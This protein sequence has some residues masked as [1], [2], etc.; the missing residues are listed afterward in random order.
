MKKVTIPKGYK[1]IKNKV[2]LAL[3]TN[4][5]VIT[6]LN[7]AGKT[8]ILKYLCENYSNRDKVFFKTQ[9]TAKQHRLTL[10]Q[11]NR[12]LQ[13]NTDN[14]SFDDVM[15]NIHDAF[16]RFFRNQ[17]YIHEYELYQMLFNESSYLYNK[18]YEFL[19]N[20]VEILSSFESNEAIKKNLGLVTEK[21]KEAFLKRKINQLISSGDNPFSNSK[22]ATV[23]KKYLENELDINEKK[24]I[25]QLEIETESELRE[26]CR[27]NANIKDKQSFETYIY[28]LVS[29]SAIRVDSVI[30][31]LSQRIYEDARANSNR[32][33]T[34]KL[35]EKINNELEHY[36][37][38]KYRIV[39]PNLYSSRYE[40][41]FEIGG[42]SKT[43][44]HFDSLSSGEKVIFELM[45]YYF[46]ADNTH[47]LEMIILDEF[48]ANL[49]PAL[50]EIYLKTVRK[51]FCNKGII[52]ILTTHSPSTV[53]EVAP[54]ELYELSI[55]NNKHTFI[56]A[57]TDE[58]KK[59]ILHKL[60]PKFVYYSEFGNLEYVLSSKSD[61]IVLV[62]GKFDKQ[63]FENH[64]DYQKY[65]FIHCHGKGNIKN[66]L[67]CL[68][69]I[70]FLENIVK[71]KLII[72]L[73]DFDDAGR[74]GI[75]EI[76]SPNINHLLA[77]KIINKESPFIKHLDNVFLAMFEPKESDSWDLVD[78]KF[79]RHQ[80]LK[81]EGIEG[82]NR[83]FEML[84]KIQ[85]E[86]RK[87]KNIKAE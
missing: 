8:T 54:N 45:S 61:V 62:E 64:E 35:W 69:A 47:G 17:D 81:K 60:A 72:G 4:L 79:L 75:H 85:Q 57:E 13:R 33:K 83:Q 24:L 38:F 65:T 50:A 71:D 68:K 76:A 12:L 15:D 48:D 10:F 74:K 52:A 32:T 9:S 23:Y 84:R 70:P 26:E 44:I 5:A 59:S 82:L 46:M 20:I 77:G 29:K 86:F 53:A 36:P 63:N 28:E 51:Q 78:K 25:D 6:G 66:F 37:N 21:D 49:N 27:R 16:L 30:T 19:S 7:G 1:G 42:D 22:G 40:I 3:K 2:D 58:V 56:C 55:T 31:K 67:V 11:R 43:L 87:D 73:F 80:E 39:K 18:G 14:L 41:S 34:K